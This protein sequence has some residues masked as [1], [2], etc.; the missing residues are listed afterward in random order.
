MSPDG[1]LVVGAGPTGLTAALL[2]EQQG[3]RTRIVERRTGPQPAPA[4][5]VV[6]ARSLEIFRAA[7]VDAGALAEASIDPADAG[8]ACWVDRLG[9]RMLGRLPFEQQGDDQLAVTPTPLRNLSQSR[10]EPLLVETLERAAGHGP[11]W[12]REW[13]A[14]HE[15]ADGV[16]SRV[17]DAESGRE[18]EIRSDFVIAADGAGSRVRKALGIDVQ[19]PAGIQSFIMVHFRARLRGVPGVPPGVLFILCDPSSNGGAF[20]VH[21]LDRDAVYMIPYDPE[22]ESLDDYGEARCA[23]LLRGGLAD[24]TLAFEVKHVGSWTMTAQLADGY[25]SG[26]VF[27]AGDAAH[28][29]PPTGGL[30]LNSGVQD[31]HNLAWKLAAVHHGHADPA[32]LESYETERRPVAQVNADQSLRNALRLIEVP[33]ALDLGD[34]PEAAKERFA[35]TLA[36]PAGLERVRDAIAAQAEHFDMPGLQLGY[37]YT[38]GALLRGPD[39]APPK[40]EVRRY[41]PTGCPGARLP[42]AWLVDGTSSLLDR[43]P[44]DRFLLIAGPRGSAWIEAL[45]G[46]DAPPTE[47]LVLTPEQVPEL[48]R[49]LGEA[50]IAAEGALLVRPDQHVAWRSPAPGADPVVALHAA[51]AAATGRDAARTRPD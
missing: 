27:L 44:V 1:V 16:R 41:D 25:R 18:E 24:P 12:G 42:H 21:D 36:D 2:L 49:W 46:L 22:T 34:V 3:V 23:E 8:F 29:F 43:V 6:N 37:C 32:L 38:E 45:A 14:S 17:R 13:I 15:D 28:R 31:A 50:G 40:L 39:D 48:D 51:F 5:H 33:V 26:R 7:G 47:S 10:L 30:G 9:G 11:E 19:G 4:A 20:I 35:A